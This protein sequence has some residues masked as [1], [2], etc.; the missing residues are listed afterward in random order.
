MYAYWVNTSVAKMTIF[1]YES[2]VTLD[3]G[4]DFRGNLGGFELVVEC[5]A[6]FGSIDK[7]LMEVLLCSFCNGWLKMMV[8]K[9]VMNKGMKKL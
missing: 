7:V 9:L 2:D 5:T 1:F 3:D 4:T 6:L 8:M